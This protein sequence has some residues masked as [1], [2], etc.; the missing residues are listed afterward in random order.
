MKASTQSSKQHIAV[1]HISLNIN[2][3]DSSG[4]KTCY[5]IIEKVDGLLCVG[6]FWF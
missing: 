2:Y 1:Y 4:F 5:R 3:L 6:Q